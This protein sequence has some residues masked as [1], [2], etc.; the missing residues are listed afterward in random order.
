[1]SAAPATRGLNAPPEPEGDG[2]ISANTLWHLAGCERRV[3]L[4]RHAPGDLAPPS[5]FDLALMERGRAHEL[6]VRARF[7]GLVG[8]VWRWGTPLEPAAVETLRLLRETRA[9]LY[10]PALI[11]PDGR[12]AG[13]PD[14]LYWDGEALVVHDAKLAEGIANKPEIPLQ[15]T[16]YARLLEEAG[17]PAARLEVTNGLG[18]ILEVARLDDALYDAAIA[19]AEA[20]LG[21]TPEPD[22]LLPHSTCEACG[23]YDRCW[24]RAEAEGRVEVL[25]GVY[26]N[27][28]PILWRMGIRTI[29]ELAARE[30]CGWS[31][32]G[33]RGS[34]RSCG[35]TSRA[36]PRTSASGTSSICGASRWIA[37]TSRSTPRRSSRSRGRRET[38]AA[39]AGSSLAPGRSSR[40]IPRRCGS[41]TPATRGRG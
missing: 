12:R 41:T 28:L 33:S 38:R 25:S 9:P 7:T 34:G 21:D 1:L 30:R 3:W 23:F 14:F 26:R 22:L 2:R 31:R 39:G 5:E 13:V 11:S 24:D 16:H 29:A 6:A 32:R 10:Q 20:L 27:H 17:F 36:I 4:L 15:L 37:A 40:P 35:S 18:R 8:P 19:R